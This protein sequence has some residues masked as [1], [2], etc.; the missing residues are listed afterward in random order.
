M[1]MTCGRYGGI[2]FDVLSPDALWRT[3]WSVQA[4]PISS[5][6]GSLALLSRQRSHEDM[7]ARARARGANTRAMI[8]TEDER[9]K[10]SFSR[11]PFGN[12]TTM[13]IRKRTALPLPESPRAPAQNSL[14]VLGLK[15]QAV[16]SQCQ[17]P[18]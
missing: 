13:K 12:G 16:R 6:A 1:K 2:R 18:R 15:Q 3:P 14:G 11:L 8:N 4:I 9:R 17:V 7:Y 10:G 5:C